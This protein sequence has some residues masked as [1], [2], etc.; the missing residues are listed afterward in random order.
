MKFLIALLSLIITIATYAE[1]AVDKQPRKISLGSVL[2]QGPYEG[3][4][5]TDVQKK[6]ILRIINTGHEQ[7]A[8]DRKE[9][10]VKFND[11][12]Y[13]RPEKIS[14]EDLRKEVKARREAR[15]NKP[16]IMRK[17]FHAKRKVRMDA[18]HS[19][20]KEILTPAQVT[21]FNANLKAIK[22]KLHKHKK[23]EQTPKNKK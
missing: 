14:I 8:K 6:K 20:I 11:Q 2:E 12:E 17:E 13:R 23:P 9:L 10:R 5:L 19:K 7:M 16:K 22:A 15:L 21:K 4:K 18:Y 3:L 1:K